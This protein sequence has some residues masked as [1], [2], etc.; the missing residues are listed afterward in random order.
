MTLEEMRN[1][2]AEVEAEITRAAEEAKTTP[3]LD[4][5][6]TRSAELIE[7]RRKLTADIEAAEKEAEEKRAAEAEALKSKTI[8]AKQEDKT[9]TDKEIRNSKEYIEAYAEYIKTGDD[10]QCRSL[11]TENATGGTVPVPEFVENRIQTAW[12]RDAI[13]GRISKSYFKG[14][15]KFGFE[16]SATGAAVHTEGTRE[17]PEE[18]LTL[19]IITMV[20]ETI[21][22]WI[23][24]SDEVLDLNGEAFLDYIYDE[25]SQKIIKKMAD[26]VVADIINAVGASTA[27]MAGQATVASTGV[28]D[29]INAVSQLSDEAADPVIILNKQSYAYYKGLQLSAQYAI[30]PF[31][32]M[33]VLFNDSL[34]A[35][36]GTGNIAIVG[37]LAGYRGNF[38]NG[39]DVEFK[40]DDLSLAEDDLVKVVGR[41]PWGHAPIAPN[42]FC[43]ITKA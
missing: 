36:T 9:V 41:L 20:P 11:L 43:V 34:D 42:R 22:K 19:G 5:L 4:A 2:L 40:Y 23:T 26:T 35:A 27:T 38:P 15:V 30:D 7:E 31:D 3:E 17:F 28:A 25:I 37:D 13:I 33:T 10:R 8:I 12:D 1:R 29:F 32:G 24:F 14:N 39:D 16:R 21:K 18:V 6:E